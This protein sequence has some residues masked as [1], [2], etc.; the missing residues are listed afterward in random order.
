MPASLTSTKSGAFPVVFKRV[1][2]VVIVVEKIEVP[3][4]RISSETAVAFYEC[5]MT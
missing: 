4:A 2:V 1:I 5:S 3:E